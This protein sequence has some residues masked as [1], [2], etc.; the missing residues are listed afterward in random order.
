MF[1]FKCVDVDVD[2]V[3]IQLL[4]ANG[5][6]EDCATVGTAVS[7]ANVVV[8]VQRHW[9]ANGRFGME[10]SPVRPCGRAHVH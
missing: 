5:V 2:R 4:R 7:V 8:V 6:Q 9:A 10:N 1:L 3:L